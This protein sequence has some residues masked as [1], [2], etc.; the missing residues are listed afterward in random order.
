M[1]IID[2]DTAAYWAGCDEQRL[3]I[4]RC[5]TCRRW[6][7][8]PKGV[9]PRCW[10]TAI[11]HE[12]VSG[13]AKVYSFTEAADREAIPAT[14]WAELLEQERLIVIGALL[15]ALGKIEIGD[16]L[17]LCWQETEDGWSPAFRRADI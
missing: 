5:E 15:P 12:E 3:L 17:T 1:R 7:H 6:I 8:P 11:A 2:L 16:E 13:A 9:C 14:V 10:G 4:A